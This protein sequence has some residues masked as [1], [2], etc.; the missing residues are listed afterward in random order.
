MK[1]KGLLS[2]SLLSGVTASLSANLLVTGVFDGPLTGGI[3][4]V[5]ELYATADIPDL[6]LYGVSSANNGGGT[7]V[8]PEFLFSGSATAGDFLYV[9]SESIEFTNYF[10]FAP[11]FTD[12]VASI[13]GDDAIEVFQNGVIIDIFGEVDVD[14]S[15]TAWDYVDGWAYRVDGTGPDGSTFAL[16][17]WTFSGINAND[18]QTSNATA[19]NPFPIGTYAVP[20]P[21]TIAAIFGLLGLGIVLMRRR[22]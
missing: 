12:G 14:G 1:I 3:P 18:G 2:L 22:R 4:K 17:N 20:E 11:T 19:A 5:I 6:S 13:N 8:T 16:G 21:S 10:G 7:T 9:A 15:G